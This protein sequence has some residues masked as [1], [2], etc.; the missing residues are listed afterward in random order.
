MGVR[1]GTN[2]M[3][4][5]RDSTSKLT[6]TLSWKP[7]NSLWKQLWPMT[8]SRF[9]FMNWLFVKSGRRTSYL[10]WNHLSWESIV[11][12][13]TF[14]STM[15]QL[16]AIYLNCSCSTEIQSKVQTNTFLNS[17]T[18]VIVN[19]SLLPTKTIQLITTNTSP[20]TKKLTKTKS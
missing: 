5:F 15:K 16:S 3:R 11:I 18:I 20:K 9:S 2:R 14:L 12:E 10:S 13:H 8:K 4:L 6:W 19:F 17:L 7:M 1:G